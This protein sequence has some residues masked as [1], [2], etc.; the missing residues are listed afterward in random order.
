MNGERSTQ[1]QMIA[2]RNYE[3]RHNTI[4]LLYWI[5]RPISTSVDLFFVLLFLN[6]PQ[7]LVTLI[8]RPV[9]RELYIIYYV[10]FLFYK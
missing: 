9:V 4:I 8:F 2:H 6:R 10:L 3:T 7:T 5:L 1:Q